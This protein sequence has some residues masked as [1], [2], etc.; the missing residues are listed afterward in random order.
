MSDVVCL[1]IL[2]AGVVAK[3]VKQW[4]EEGK[5]VLVDQME[6]HTGGCAVN[7]GIDLAR[8][9][10]KVSVMG[11]VGNDAF[12]D[13]MIA[14]LQREGIGT[15][16]VQRQEGVNTSATMV[17]VA[18]GGERSFIHYLGANAEL[19]DE[20]VD[21]EI[22][23]GAKIL[24]IGSALLVPKLDG[25]PLARV[26]RRAREMGVTTCVDT[27]WDSRGRWMELVG[28]ALPYTDICVPSLEEA[29]MITGEHEPEAIARVLLAA[30]VKTVGIKMGEQGCYVRAG[31]EEYLVPPFCVEAVDANGAGDAW[32]AGFLCG[33]VNGLSLLDTARLANAVGAMSVTAM[34]A[35]NGVRSLPE[36]EA[37]MARTPVRQ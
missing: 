30:G 2:V 27:A 32:V 12:G 4:P 6:L 8:L 16:G 7:T 24:H 20:D 18:A 17:C 10:V 31:G 28:P 14:A 34:G 5:L 15:D 13:F 19:T 3:P 26:L 33:V 21:F 1:G 37:F 9:G 11:K 36:T 25:E 23:R 35:S 22:I 29:R